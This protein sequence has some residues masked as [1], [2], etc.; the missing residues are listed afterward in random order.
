MQVTEYATVDLSYNSEEDWAR[1]LT[2]K[3]LDG[4]TLA[5]AL[6]VNASKAKALFARTRDLT[7][8]EVAAIRTPAIPPAG[9]QEV[10]AESAAAPQVEADVSPPGLPPEAAAPEEAPAAAT[11]TG[12]T[13][14]P[15]PPLG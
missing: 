2:G 10:E 5:F 3:V 6:P 1:Q 4:W 13:T 11:I 9:P 15:T 7:D 14:G 12:P 8:A